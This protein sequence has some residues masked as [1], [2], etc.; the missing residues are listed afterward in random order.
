MVKALLLLTVVASTMSGQPRPAPADFAVR[1][2]FGCAGVD[3]LD[4]AK[5]TYEREMSR[6]PRQVA[7][8]A[9]N[10]DLKRRWFHLV[11]EARF[12]DVRERLAVGA[13]CEPSM[14]YTRRC[15]AKA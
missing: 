11:H 1:L 8:I 5:G 15:Q 13:I 10:D 6:E 2:E 12:F 4:S 3:V 14:R 7:K 9:I